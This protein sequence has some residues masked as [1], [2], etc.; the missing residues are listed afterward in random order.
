MYPPTPL[1]GGE[2]SAVVV[3]SIHSPSYSLA[4]TGRS[5][6]LLVLPLLLSTSPDSTPPPRSFILCGDAAW[7]DAD[8]TED[9]PSVIELLLLLVT[10]N[11]SIGSH[12]NR[13]KSGLATIFITSSTEIE[14]E[15]DVSSNIIDTSK[16]SSLCTYTWTLVLARSKGLYTRGVFPLL[17]LLLLDKSRVTCVVVVLLLF[18]S[19]SSAGAAGIIVAVLD[20]KGVPSSSFAPLANEMDRLFSVCC[21]RWSLVPLFVSE[22]DG[23]SSGTG[24]I[25]LVFDAVIVTDLDGGGFV[26]LYVLSASSKSCEKPT[27]DVEDSTAG[28]GC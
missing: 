7:E 13:S 16:N 6:L 8:D 12:H 17:P 28:F 22:A 10:I 2:S 3:A 9:V 19:S 23:R 15:S 21:C 11:V 1:L 24:G 5:G 14:C 20:N 26:W 18:S 25:M 27:D 4:D